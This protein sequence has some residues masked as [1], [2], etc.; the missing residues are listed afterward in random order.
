M[1]KLSTCLPHFNFLSYHQK[2]VI[3]EIIL[4]LNSIL[5]TVVL[6]LYSVI[7]NFQFDLE[8]PIQR[9]KINFLNFFQSGVGRYTK[10]I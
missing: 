4:M 5:V 2:L 1:A 9:N 7:H 10:F 3:L 6:Y 8:K